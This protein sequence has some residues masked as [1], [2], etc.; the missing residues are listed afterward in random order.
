VASLLAGLC[1]GALT[2]PAQ[3]AKWVGGGGGPEFGLWNAHQNWGEPGKAIP[4]GTAIFQTHEPTSITISLTDQHPN[5]PTNIGTIQFDAGALAYSFTNNTTFNVTS[6]GTVNN[7]ASQQTFINNSLLSFLNSSTAGNTLP[8][9]IVHTTNGGLTS[10]FGSSSGELARFITDSGG[11]VD[12]STL[13]SAGMTSGSIEGSGTYNLGS[14]QLTTGLN[15]LPTVVSG[16]IADGGAAGGTGGSL[17]KVGTGT[18]TLSGANTYTGNT[19]VDGG[20]LLVNGTLGSGS[21]NVSSGATLGG[22]G[23]IGGPVTI[24]DGGIL[25][26]GVSPKP[27]TLTVGPLTLNP[28]STLNYKLGISDVVDNGVSD[29]VHVNGSLT[30]AGQLNVTDVGGFGVGT[31]RLFNYT[32]SLTDHGLT[33]HSFPNGFVSSNFS[34]VTAVAGQVDLVVLGGGVPT[35]FWDGSHTTHG[36]MVFG[37]GGNG[38]WNNDPANTNWTNH[39]GTVNAG[40]GNGFA[41]FAGTAGTVNLGANIHFA[42]MQFLTDGYVIQAQPSGSQTLLAAPDTRI[43]VDVGVEATISA[44][45]ANDPSSGPATL[46]K[47]DG[48]TLI[49]SGENTYTGGT[50]IA[51]GALQLGDGGTTG[52]IAGNVTDDGTFA[53]NRSHSVTFSGMISGIGSLVQAGT[54]ALALTRTNAYFGGTFVNSGTLVAGASGALGSGFVTV[55]DRS[56]LRIDPGVTVTNFIQLNNGGSLDNAGIVQVTATIEGPAAAVTTSGGATITNEAGAK[57]SGIGLIAIES[58]NG[59][60]TITNSGLI[61]GTEGILLRGGGT[62]TN[63]SG[64]AIN[65]VAGPAIATAAPASTAGPP[66]LPGPVIVVN[67]G[68]ITGATSGIILAAGGFLTNNA[69]G[70]VMGTGGTAAVITGSQSKLSNAGQISGD[71]QL[72]AVANTA[73][74]LTGGRISGNLTLNSAGTNQVILDGS[75]IQLLSQSVTGTISNAGALTKQGTGEWIL[76]KSLSPPVSAL[77]SSGLLQVNSGQVLTSPTVTVGAGGELSGLGTI[78]ASVINNGLVTPGDAP[79]TLTVTGNYTQSSSGTLN[80]QFASRSHGLLAVGGTAFLGGTLRLSLVNGFVPPSAQRITIVSAGT[81]VQG[82][83]SLVQQPTATT[84]TVVY[85]PKD[86][87]V[88]VGQVPFQ[89]FACDPNTRSVLTALQSVRNTATGDL[90][91]VIG[92]LNGLP[93]DELCNAGSQISPLPVPSLPTQVINYFDNQST[94][95]DQRLWFFEQPFDPQHRWDIYV[96]GSGIFGRIKNIFDLP[97]LDFDT[98]TTTPGGEYRFSP[99]LGLGVCAGYAHSE[100]RFSDGTRVTANTPNAGTYGLWNPPF[101]GPFGVDLAFG[102]GYNSYSVSRPIRFGDPIDRVASSNPR[103]KYFK[104]R[105]G[106]SYHK[107]FGKLNVEVLGSYEYAN[108][109]N[110]QFYEHGANSLDTRVGS[111][112]VPSL[113][114]RFGIHLVYDIP[115]TTKVTITPDLRL[116]WIHEYLYGTRAIPVSLDSG[117]GPNFTIDT[118]QGPRDEYISVIGFYAVFGELKGYLYWTSD[119]GSG[120]VTSN[121]IMGGITLNF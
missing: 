93:T 98:G 3:D 29:L 37:R 75:G 97:P 92:V 2:T 23:T 77:I 83:F 49:L 28:A 85:D 5:P 94:E 42:G 39:D 38:T 34:I 79:G 117:A 9:T 43:R 113:R 118:P 102:G 54:G 101:M 45:I 91:E 62:I 78:A 7:S 46:T 110:D 27:G 65:S 11:K 8:S 31:Y 53:F 47:S 66:P 6:G 18:L 55:N 51:A 61:S 56:L 121:S 40:W 60:A 87:Q 71:V 106:T 17:I 14:K 30:L 59:P 99:S 84:F 4:T 10:F 120:V 68:T 119:F 44:P 103:S 41:V 16:V 86:V 104:Y 26:P 89:N 13:T 76:D 80:I 12:I 96:N 36:N 50:T 88:E 108:I 52:S 67:A 107:K 25:S 19:A 20:T 105:L 69:G 90:G 82:T 33:V 111:Y 73:Q 15:N 116:T 74:L 22:T 115:V 32:G 81:A 1:I 109:N 114:Q 100:S 112:D 64:G 70:Q 24:Q 48:G 58:L 35:Q 21:V 57:I 95:L 72:N 63:N